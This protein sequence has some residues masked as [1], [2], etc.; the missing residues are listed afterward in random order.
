LIKSSE[1]EKYMYKILMVEEDTKKDVSRE[2][3]VGL[4][5]QDVAQVTFTKAD[6]SERVMNCTLLSE[7]LNERVPP[8]AD[9]PE[10]KAP[11]TKAVNPHTVAVY[12]ITADGWRSFRLDSVKSIGFPDSIFSDEGITYPTFE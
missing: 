3:V 6:G 9:S 1:K 4:L 10:S 5:R 12:D 11:S 8:I 7:V 2:D